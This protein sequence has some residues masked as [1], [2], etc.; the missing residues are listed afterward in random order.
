[1]KALD[2]ITIIVYTKN[3]DISVA[4]ATKK[5]KILMQ[6]R[7]TPII[8]CPLFENIPENDVLSMTL[9]LK[10]YTKKYKKGSVILLAGEEVSEMGI[11]ISGEAEAYRENYDGSRLLI[12][13]LKESDIFSEMMFPGDSKNPLTF[14]AKTE[15]EIMYI[16]HDKILTTCKNACPCHHKLLKNLLGTV[17]SKYWDLQT[18]IKYLTTPTLREK[19]LEFLKDCS[20]GKKGTFDIPY[21]RDAMAEYLNADR[22]ALSRELSRMKKDGIID[23]KKNMFTIFYNK[24]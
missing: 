9:C 17:S 4:Q 24:L 14:I 22:S 23:Y 7:F 3:K 15:T 11:V 21:D 6:L 18:K 20:E 8:N 5:R 13:L 1:M 12:S 2:F 16:R 19:I 10:A